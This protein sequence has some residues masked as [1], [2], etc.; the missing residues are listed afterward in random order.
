MQTPPTRPDSMETPPPV[1]PPEVPEPEP[2]RW[3]S[4]LP[5]NR[6]WFWVVVGLIVLAIIGSFAADDSDS[7]A[8]SSTSAFNGSFSA[9]PCLDAGALTSYTDDAEQEVV[10]AQSS[11]KVFDLDAAAMHLDNAG[12]D[13]DLIASQSSEFP[14]LTTP[15]SDAADDL[16]DAADSL[17]SGSLDTT[18]LERANSDIHDIVT[19]TNGL[20]S[21]DAC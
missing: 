8:T 2:K 20:S 19:A 4:A 11:I 18:Y 7:T 3:Y 9:D 14:S 12:D 1:S 17:R 13:Y 10:A 6:W 21:S 16:H 5:L 15:A